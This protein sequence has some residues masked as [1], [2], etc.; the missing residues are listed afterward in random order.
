VFVIEALKLARGYHV[1]YFFLFFGR[2]NLSFKPG[3]MTKYGQ[4][5]IVRFRRS[6]KLRK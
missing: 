1:Q 2:S 4:H 5:P 6:H 3:L